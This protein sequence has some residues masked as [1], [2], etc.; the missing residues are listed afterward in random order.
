MYN[1]ATTS[2][3]T[4]DAPYEQYATEAPV[5]N[6]LDNLD[7]PEDNQSPNYVPAGFCPE[8]DP[9]TRWARYTVRKSY[10]LEA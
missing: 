2:R 6:E 7:L 9:I 1:D 5:Q 10:G 3:T 8:L 4:H